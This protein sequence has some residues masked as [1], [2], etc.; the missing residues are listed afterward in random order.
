[1]SIALVFFCIAS[2]AGDSAARE[3]HIDR[4]ATDVRDD[5]AAYF[6][7]KYP[8]SDESGNDGAVFRFFDE[9][10]THP[11]QGMVHSWP[12]GPFYSFFE[13]T[14][15]SKTEVTVT[16]LDFYSEKNGTTCRI[17]ISVSTE[18]KAKDS[19][20]STLAPITENDIRNLLAPNRAE[21]PRKGAEPSPSFQEPRERRLRQGVD[22]VKHISSLFRKHLRKTRTHHGS[23]PSCLTVQKER[24]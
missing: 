4:P 18:G 24:D 13:R 1:M 19:P 9:H 15:E 7:K 11:F 16:R 5:V 10:D 22:G 23:G 20:F 21:A 2:F 3:L 12:H 6:H 17:V 14:E 8:S